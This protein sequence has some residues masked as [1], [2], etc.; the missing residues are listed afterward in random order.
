MSVYI[1]INIIKMPNLIN[2][3]KRYLEILTPEEQLHEINRMIKMINESYSPCVNVNKK[4]SMI[5]QLNIL[6]KELLSRYK[7]HY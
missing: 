3:F 2:N 4:F 5:T 6:K 1:F 7:F